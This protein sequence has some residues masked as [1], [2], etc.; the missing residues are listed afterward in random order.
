MEHY[1]G[2]ERD[3]A[4]HNQGLEQSVLEKNVQD[5]FYVLAAAVVEKWPFLLQQPQYIIRD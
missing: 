1:H 2:M 5:L 3:L 4:N